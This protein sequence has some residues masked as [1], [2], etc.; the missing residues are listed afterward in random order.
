MTQYYWILLD[1]LVDCLVYIR[2]VDCLMESGQEYAVDS[3]VY[4]SSADFSF[5]LTVYSPSYFCLN[6]G[7]GWVCGS[8]DT[9]PIVSVS[10]STSFSALLSVDM[11]RIGN[12]S[13]AFLATTSEGLVSD[14]TW[15]CTTN[16]IST[17]PMHLSVFW[18]WQ[19]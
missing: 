7:T 5:T 10:Y 3:L 8:P 1:H 6:T 9:V 18:L 14:G 15:P 12:S 19:R 13:L 4:T 2:L 11:L 16:G 17:S